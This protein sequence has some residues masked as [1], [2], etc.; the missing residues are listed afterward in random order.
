[1]DNINPLTFETAPLDA[2]YHTNPG[3]GLDAPV[4]EILM[5]DPPWPCSITRATNA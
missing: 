4:D 5:I 1:M 3:R 2:L